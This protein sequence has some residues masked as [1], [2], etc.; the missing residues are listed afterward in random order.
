MG[1]LAIGSNTLHWSRGNHET[2]SIDLEAA[3][4]DLLQIEHQGIE[5]AKDPELLAALGGQGAFGQTIAHQQR[6]A[7]RLSD[8]D[9][10]T[11]GTGGHQLHQGGMG[12]GFQRASDLT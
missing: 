10:D 1:E 11:D 9:H 4:A 3:D 5:L 2:G 8:G 12:N 7:A 6:P